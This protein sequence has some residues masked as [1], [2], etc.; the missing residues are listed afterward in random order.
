M[1]G[2]YIH[3]PFCKQACY[4]CNFHFSTNTKL[5]DQMVDAICQEVRLRHSYL[6]TTE[7]DSIYFGGGTPSLLDQKQ[8][9]KILAQ[10]SK[11][12]S[13][14]EHIE[15]TLEANPDDI[16]KK[17]VQELKSAGI[18]RLSIGI[19]SFIDEEL[20]ACNRA[21][22]AQE[23]I[24]AVQKAKAAGIH[25]ISIDLIYGMPQST[26]SSWIGNVEKAIALD[27][28]HISSYALTVEPKTALD[29]MVS[30]G[31][32]LIPKDENTSQQYL[33]LIQMLADAG[34]EHYEISN[35]ARA[36]K[37][38]K[39]NTSYWQSKSYLGLGPSAHSYQPSA[40]HWNIANNAL[41]IKNI[42]QGLLP[43]EIEK[44]SPSDEYNEFVMTRLRTMWG[45][46]KEELNQRF[47]QFETHLIQEIKTHISHQRIIESPSHYQLSNAGKLL[48]DGIASD[49][50]WVE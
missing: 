13:W 46:S 50:F 6:D 23:S 1:A 40:R 9:V 34:Y 26:L 25:N 22:N 24:T 14:K 29:H 39:H 32:V 44:L 12:Y 33:S 2:I 28:D 10:L 36:E 19:Q 41:Y 48:A 3:I 17:Y 5:R 8:I 27:V 16:S 15:I 30:K 11:F 42:E 38:A 4:Y 49:L 35:F 21:H 43:I 37:Y 20:S 7:I 18:N 47:S 31:E 45:I